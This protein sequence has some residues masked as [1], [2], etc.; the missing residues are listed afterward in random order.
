[1]DEQRRPPCGRLP[2]IRTLV[3]S[4]AGLGLMVGAEVLAGQDRNQAQ[5]QAQAHAQDG[6]GTGPLDLRMLFPAGTGAATV[7][8]GG[9]AATMPAEGA[10]AISNDEVGPVE[11]SNTVPPAPIDP[12]PSPDTTTNVASQDAPAVESPSAPENVVADEAATAASRWSERALPGADTA[13]QAVSGGVSGD[14][15]SEALEVGGGLAGVLLIIWAL[16]ALVRRHQGNGASGGILAKAKR[17]PG[18]ASVLARYP[19]ARGQQVVLLKVG[20]RVIVTHQGNGTMSTLSE[21]T[22]QDEVAALHAQIS[23]VE[24]VDHERRFE[25]QLSSSIEATPGVDQ[26]A[27]VN[28]M[29]GLVAETVDLTKRTRGIKARPF[30]GGAA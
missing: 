1:M 13:D 15:A 29:P 30:A 19:I 18:V 28:G 5:P 2:G 10:T 16:R 3:V 26:L 9:D 22:D 27:T 25:A 23:G 11:P 24:R 17:P 7:V 14:G 12:L 20:Q 21:I 8:T 4:C 6:P